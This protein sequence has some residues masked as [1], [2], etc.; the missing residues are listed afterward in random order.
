MSNKRRD[1][2][3]ALRVFVASITTTAGQEYTTTIYGPTP[4]AAEQTYLRE[5]NIARVVVRSEMR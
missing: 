2:I 1:L 5:P 4:D 3:P